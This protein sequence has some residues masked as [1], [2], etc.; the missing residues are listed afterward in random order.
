MIE[1]EETKKYEAKYESKLTSGTDAEKRRIR[2][3]ARQKGKE[4]Y[5]RALERIIHTTESEKQTLKTIL[6]ECVREKQSAVKLLQR[7]NIYI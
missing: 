1:Q 2:K 7:H 5:V 6:D 3:E 4:A